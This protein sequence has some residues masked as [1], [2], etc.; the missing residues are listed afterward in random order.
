VRL[1]GL[2]VDREETITYGEVVM[3]IILWVFVFPVTLAL[4]MLLVEIVQF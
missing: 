2:G 3:P 1:C 4:V